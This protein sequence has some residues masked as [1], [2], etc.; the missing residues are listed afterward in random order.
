M[1]V[2]GTNRQM[3]YDFIVRPGADPKNISLTGEGIEGL[4]TD[5]DGNLLIKTALTDIKHLK[6]VIYQEVNGKRSTV[7]G[8]VYCHPKQN[9]F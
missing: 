9:R 6:P 5:A 4:E 8:F 3:E 1:K 2:Y 7:N